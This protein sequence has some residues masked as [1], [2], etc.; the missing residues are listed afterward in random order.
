MTVKLLDRKNL[1]GFVA[2][3]LKETSVFGV[4]GKGTGRFDFAPLESPEDLCLDYDVTLLP[5]KKYFIPQEE[6][7]LRF[8]RGESPSVEP[9]IEAQ[10]SILIGV[11]PYDIKAIAQ[12]DKVFA[13][14]HRD[15]NYLR[16]RER[17]TIIGVDMTRAS[18]KAFCASMNSAVVDDG[19]DLMLTDIGE[20]YTVSIGTEKGAQLLEKHATVRDATD[21]EIAKRDQAREKAKGLFGDRKLDMPCTDLPELLRGKERHPVWKM[22]AERCLSCGS[23]NLVCPTCYCFDVKDETD[24]QLTKGRRYR[25]WDGCLLEDFAAVGSGENFREE[26]MERYRH[27]FYR[28][29]QYLYMKYG[30]IACVGC[31]RCA[32]ACLPDIA[33]PVKVY[34]TLKEEL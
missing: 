11:H 3:L 21:E 20:A 2:G 10:E 15:E 27:R 29:G 9:V 7:L 8:T 26:R 17:S 18:E 5:P 33:D 32:S 12:M 28:K 16:K 13:D 6:T 23:C 34:N 22:K 1:N 24:L 31:G 19:F 4:A 14:T 30:D 25:V